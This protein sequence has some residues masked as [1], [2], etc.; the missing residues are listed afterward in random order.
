MSLYD[1]AA[2]ADMSWFL[3]IMLVEAAQLDENV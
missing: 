1:Q 2:S 3:L